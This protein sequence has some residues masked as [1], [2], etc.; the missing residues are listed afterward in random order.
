VACCLLLSGA[1][2]FALRSERR[3]ASDG[4]YV[5][6]V[7]TTS[8]VIAALTPAPESLVVSAR[9]ADGEAGEEVTARDAGPVR[10]HGLR[11]E[12]LTPDTAY[13]Y[14]VRDGAGARVAAASFRTAPP[15]GKRPVMIVALGDSGAFPT[16]RFSTPTQARLV[17]TIG[18]LAAP[19]A[20]LHMGD[21][22]YSEGE[23]ARYRGAFFKPFAPLIRE[24]PMYVTIG[25]HDRNTERAAPLLEVFHLPESEAGGERY[26]SFDL[27]D[28]HVACVDTYTS[29]FG[30][31][32]EQAAWLDA[33]LAATD[34]RWKIVFTH[35]APFTAATQRLP[36]PSGRFERVR[37]SLSPIYAKHG[38]RLVLSGHDHSYVRYKPVDGV[39]YVVTGGGGYRLY[40]VTPD[41]RIERWAVRHHFVRVRA[42]PETLQ[43]DA[44]GIDGETFDSF[45]VTRN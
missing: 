12:G 4:C 5:Q 8:A 33:D 18:R 36:E 34:R 15:P 28:V 35:V 22:V 32:S 45:T 40:D 37:A 6:S 42:T 14:E 16:W 13:A 19:D 31:G 11:L 3:F 17:A 44:I 29:E 26:Y 43:V 1:A 9:P 39:H 24:V 20:I 21:L 10:I 2:Y 41:D 25:N 30:D 7:T 27:G 23:R 38:V